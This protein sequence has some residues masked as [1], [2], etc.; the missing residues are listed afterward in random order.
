MV[1]SASP[2]VCL[3]C[4]CGVC[5]C[6]QGSGESGSW[7]EGA[8]LV[9][10]VGFVSWWCVVLGVRVSVRVVVFSAGCLCVRVVGGLHSASAGVRGIDGSGGDWARR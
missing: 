8:W 2:F 4:L 9:G 10:V 7:S 1:L 6:V 5:A 3:V